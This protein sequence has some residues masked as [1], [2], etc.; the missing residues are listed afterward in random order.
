MNKF[1]LTLLLFF[2][3]I[4]G[5]PLATASES[6]IREE[7]ILFSAAGFT[8]KSGSRAEQN[9]R[10]IEAA[11]YL[12]IKKIEELFSGPGGV[13]NHLPADWMET[14]RILNTIPFET[15]ETAELHG[16]RL[17]GRVHLNFKEN[18]SISGGNSNRELLKTTF[19]IPKNR[20]FTGEEISFNLSGS[21]D[22]Y[23][24][25]LDINEKKEAIQLLPN[26]FR[27][28]NTFSGGRGYIFPDSDLGDN[29]KLEVSPPYGRETIRLIASSY[30]ITT[31]LPLGQQDVFASSTRSFQ[32]L[33]LPV[34]EEITDSLMETGDRH[35]YQFVQV[36]IRTLFLKTEER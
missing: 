2:T 32:E 10:A 14:I 33:M 21:G 19:T 20:F 36:S 34:Y 8:N 7:T 1:F 3:A 28:D 31:I 4:T 18:G 23:A 9:S 22:F 24:C 11:R 16:V 13:P 30:P 6:F 15:T 27:Q 5:V 26:S 29:F 17:L 35:Y 12:V 25:I